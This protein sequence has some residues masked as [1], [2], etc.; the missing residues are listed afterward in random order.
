[1][2]ETRLTGETN[3]KFDALDNVKTVRRALA[4]HEDLTVDSAG[5]LAVHTPLREPAIQMEHA[6]I[7]PERVSSVVKSKA[8]KARAL[9]QRA[10]HW[11]QDPARIW[12]VGLTC[13]IAAGLLTFMILMLTNSL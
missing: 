10:K 12:I 13:V 9:L 8:Q 3:A 1:M 7:G 11:T 2:S 5:L 6:I 4:S